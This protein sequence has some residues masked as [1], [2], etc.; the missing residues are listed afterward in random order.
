MYVLCV[1]Q[2]LPEFGKSP[3]TLS[4][5]IT[6]GILKRIEAQYIYEFQFL[7]SQ[8]IFIYLLLYVPL[9]KIFILHIFI[10]HNFDTLCAVNLPS[11]RTITTVKISNGSFIL[12]FILHLL[13]IH[14]IIFSSFSYY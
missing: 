13:L 7:N 2:N 8:I 5:K 3:L 11:K 12:Q 10:V 6:I 9:T 1:I 14:L 4:I